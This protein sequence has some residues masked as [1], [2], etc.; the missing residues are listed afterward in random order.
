MTTK[1][2]WQLRKPKG[3]ASSV[4]DLKRGIGVAGFL[5]INSSSFNG[6]WEVAPAKPIPPE[7]V[8]LSPVWVDGNLVSGS[9]TDLANHLATWPVED[10]KRS[11][12]KARSRVEQLE[13]VP[14]EPS[15]QKSLE[16][17]NLVHGVLGS[18]EASQFGLLIPR[19]SAKLAQFFPGSQLRVWGRCV[20][21]GQRYRPV[22]LLASATALSTDEIRKGF[23]AGGG[24]AMHGRGEDPAYGDP[25][26]I[27]VNLLD[28]VPTGIPFP[29]GALIFILEYA[30]P[31]P[32]WDR[33]DYRYLR[34]I[35]GVAPFEYLP[36][37]PRAAPPPLVVNG[38]EQDVVRGWFVDRYNN[39]L[40]TL[41]DPGNFCTTGGEW[42][43]FEHHLSVMTAL[44]ALRVTV[45]L[46]S[47]SVRGTQ[48]ALFWDVVDLYAGITGTKVDTL[49]HRD[50]WDSV[51]IPGI[52]TIPGNLG[53]TLE[54]RAS[55][56]YQEIMDTVIDGIQQ[57]SR[58]RTHKVSVGIHGSRTWITRE[59]YVAGFMRQWR[60]TVR[61][62]GNCR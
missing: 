54:G 40:S 47:A 46:M 29:A 6:Y 17:F 3:S 51:V 2:P 33:V 10:V 5:T 25:S 38:L 52:Q 59:D 1:P 26:S 11:N 16:M 18:M 56:V 50:F 23:G 13:A 61:T 15:I 12:S 53:S 57:P 31:A 39:L 34:A 27:Y 19:V 28:S 35:H 60:A 7:L 36:A 4:D 41:G 43:P 32:Q 49:M 44:R 42:K 62:C 9:V 22:H 37:N 14:V 8:E 24:G 30:P 58:V 20:A 45:Q 55:E 21:P 48:L